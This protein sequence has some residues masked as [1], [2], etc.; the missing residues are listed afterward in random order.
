[1]VGEGKSVNFA[2]TGHT[3]NDFVVS[4]ESG[5]AKVTKA[6]VSPTVSLTMECEDY[7]VL[8]C[9]RVHPSNLIN[10]G[11]ITIRGDVHLGQSI[12]QRM[13]FMI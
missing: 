8:T 7:L 13:N 9:G 1:M 10:S 5:R 11:R 6:G 3:A 2:I 12:V 4:V